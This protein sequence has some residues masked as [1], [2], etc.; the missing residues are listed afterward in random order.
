MSKEKVLSLFSE[1]PLE[2]TDD[3]LV[4]GKRGWKEEITVHLNDAGRVRGVEGLH[5]ELSGRR[6][7][8]VEGNFKETISPEL[9]KFLDDPDRLTGKRGDF[10]QES[11]YKR[12]QLT[13]QVGC[14]GYWFYLGDTSG[15]HH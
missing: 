11:T 6:V 9:F 7:A 4:M 2:S 3:Y 15:R 10:V 12:Y 8:G 1:P 5:L 14:T 13:F